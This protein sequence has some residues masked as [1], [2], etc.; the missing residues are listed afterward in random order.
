MPP[1]TSAGLQLGGFEQTHLLQLDLD[2]RGNGIVVQ[3]GVVLERQGDVLRQRHRIEQGTALKRH[4]DFATQGRELIFRHPVDVLTVDQDP[5]RV[6][7]QHAHQHLEE[8]GLAVAG[9]SQDAQGLAFL[10][11]EG[12]VVEHAVRTEAAVHALD[13]DHGAHGKTV[14]MA[15]RSSLQD[16]FITGCSC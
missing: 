2:H 7:G 10:E 14:L 8:G 5:S 4:P 1:E 15:R 16:T 9:G 3:P 6:R 13:F 12:D 11:L